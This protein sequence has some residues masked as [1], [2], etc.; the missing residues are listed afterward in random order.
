MAPH[1]ARVTF[2]GLLNRAVWRMNR[3][4]LPMRG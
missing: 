3:D 2:A 1:L 4:V